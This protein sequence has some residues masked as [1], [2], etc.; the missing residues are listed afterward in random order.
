MSDNVASVVLTIAL[1]FFMVGR[2]VGS[3]LMRYVKAEY[4]LLGCAI[5]SVVCMGVVVL[6]LGKVSTVALV[7]N[8]AFEAIMFP[9][10]F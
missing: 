10:I 8:Y 7:L 1:A 3:W 2:F 5:G 4:M 9:T 6:N